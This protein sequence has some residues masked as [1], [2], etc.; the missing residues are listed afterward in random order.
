MHYK[1]L[2]KLTGYALRQNKPSGFHRLQPDWHFVEEITGSFLNT[3]TKL[4][5]S[6][7]YNTQD[8]VAKEETPQMP[9]EDSM[10][11]N[12]VSYNMCEYEWEEESQSMNYIM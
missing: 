3:N 9:R 1:Y 8:P 10:V 5:F 4:P 12:P 11:S 2:E 7:N 6:G